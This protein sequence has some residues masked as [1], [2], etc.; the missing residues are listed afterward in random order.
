MDKHLQLCYCSHVSLSNKCVI[1][2]CNVFNVYWSTGH[3]TKEKVESMKLPNV[4]ENYMKTLQCKMNYENGTEI[5]LMLLSVSD[6]MIQMVNMFPVVFFVDVTC[7]TNCQNKP[8]FLMVVKDTNGETHI[9]NICVLPSEKKWV[10]NE[11]FKCVFVEH[12]GEHM[13]CWIFW[14]Q[15]TKT[16]LHTNP[17]WTPFLQGLKINKEN[18]CMFHVMAKKFKE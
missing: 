14:C 5:V 12:Y 6:E 16:V 4:M 8:L 1:H 9:G 18:T 2:L 13:I 15:L 3:T 11:M 7:S 17:Q 10:F